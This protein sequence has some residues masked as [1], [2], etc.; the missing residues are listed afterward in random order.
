NA[1]FRAGQA[2]T[3]HAVASGPD[4]LIARSVK[5]LDFRDRTVISRDV[6]SSERSASVSGGGGIRTHDGVTHA[7]F[8]DRCNRRL[9]HPSDVHYSQ[10]NSPFLQWR[11]ALERQPH[12]HPTV[13]QRLR[14]SPQIAP[15][16]PS[17]TPSRQ[18]V[19]RPR[20]R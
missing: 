7:G 19:E 9:C 2:L 13:H 17:K 16:A 8:Q 6:A 3:L 18:N 11:S 4:R 12:F 15:D 20:S 10:G 1:T 14:E 5:R